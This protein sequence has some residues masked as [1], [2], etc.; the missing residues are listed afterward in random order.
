MALVFFFFLGMGGVE[1][2]VTDSHVL[3][4]TTVIFKGLVKKCSFYFYHF[5]FRLIIV[6]VLVSER[7]KG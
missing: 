7:A 1:S 2:M 5:F 4:D 3:A 6:W